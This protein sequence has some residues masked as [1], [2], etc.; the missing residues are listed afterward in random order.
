MI[1]KVNLLHVEHF[2]FVGANFVYIFF[3]GQL[4]DLNEYGRYALAYSFL[5]LI[6]IIQNGF[7]YEPMQITL[8]S[9]NH[10]KNSIDYISFFLSQFVILI[11]Y[12]VWIAA[13]KLFSIKSDL[14]I[15]E[16]II[17]SPIISV[18]IWY[19]R[20]LISKAQSVKVLS[21][22]VVYFL[23]ISI[24]LFY[25]YAE[26][27]V[28]TE[29]AI[30]VF[31]LCSLF[32]LI[33]LFLWKLIARSFVSRTSF[34]I[35]RICKV[36]LSCDL[37]PIFKIFFRFGFMS[38][39]IALCTWFIGNGIFFLGNGIIS[40]SEVGLFRKILNI[41]TPLLQLFS[42]NGVLLLNKFSKGTDVV[43]VKECI[44]KHIKLSLPLVVVYII[45][46]YFILFL[47]SSYG[48]FLSY[49]FIFS[50]HVFLLVVVVIYVMSEGINYIVGSY[51]R[52][53]FSLLILLKQYLFGVVI[54]L[55]SIGIGRLFFSF[56]S[57]LNIAIPMLLSSMSIWLIWFFSFVKLD[58]LL[59][60]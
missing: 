25:L 50:N 1:A 52:S 24:G 46:C 57:I 54:Y 6:Q 9:S 2:V 38:L 32:V 58:G 16:M 36:I 45:A 20:N 47:F 42:I 40:S 41:T 13:V 29:L 3:V 5:F 26:N 30:K 56:D 11:V 53:D 21:L 31:S 10:D 35:N 8:N 12:V 59:S 49:Y 33:F 55:F 17:Y 4:M 37:M 28:K 43:E 15:L 51:M 19:R 60:K 39:P 48:F 34:N 7:S 27:S 23:F 22:S 44:Y 18:L 14:G